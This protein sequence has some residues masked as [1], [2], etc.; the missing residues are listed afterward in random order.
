[1]IRETDSRFSF[2]SYNALSLLVYRPWW[3]EGIVHGMT[4][5]DRSFGGEA[6]YLEAKELCRAVGADLLVALKQT[7]G[8]RVFDAR[9]EVVGR[10]IS[11]D[12]GSC[13]QVGQYDAIIIPHKKN[14][15][16]KVLAYGVTT[17][18]CVPVVIRGE[19]E[20]ALVHAGWR[21]LANGIIKKVASTFGVIREV[22]IFPCAG[23]ERYEVGKE[24]LEAIGASASYKNAVNGKFLLNT[25]ETARNQ[26]VEFVAGDRVAVSGICTISD[27]RFH[28]HRRDGLVAGRSL[29]FWTPAKR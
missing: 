3:E 24:V 12:Q 26:L 9:V 11:N 2:L 18:D 6:L 16:A 15:S 17:A 1:M 13:V 29:T 7:H 25:A 14:L 27:R 10:E 4:L 20:W 5:S 22:A 8:D 23:G 19:E 28:S 21:G